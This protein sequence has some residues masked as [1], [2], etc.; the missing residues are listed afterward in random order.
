MN[1][2]LV[3]LMRYAKE[4]FAVSTS[5]GRQYVVP[6]VGGLGGGWV[7]V[8]SGGGAAGGPCWRDMLGGLLAGPAWEAAAGPAAGPPQLLPWRV[9]SSAWR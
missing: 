3:M 9:G 4:P 8:D 6:K 7:V 5:D 2:P 1:P